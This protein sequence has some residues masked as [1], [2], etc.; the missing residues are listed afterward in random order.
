VTIEAPAPAAPFRHGPE[1]LIHCIETG[2]PVQGFCSMEVSRNAQEILEAGKRAAD[3]GVTQ[4]LP[5]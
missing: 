1:Y 5:L 2:E 3:T 4:K